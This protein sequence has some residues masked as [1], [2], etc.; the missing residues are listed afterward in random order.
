MPGKWC[1]KEILQHLIDTERIFMYRCFRIARNDKTALAGFDQNI[2]VD[3]S[4]AVNKSIEILLDEFRVVRESSI[5]LL[6]SLSDENLNILEI[7]M[8]VRCLLV[9]R[10]LLL[11]VTKFGIS[12]LSKKNIYSYVR[13]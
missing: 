7:P 6:N 12:I 9:Q 8:V 11:L 1:I 4:S 2:Y 5:S 3:P 10:H 13:N